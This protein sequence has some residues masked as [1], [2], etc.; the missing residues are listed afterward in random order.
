MHTASRILAVVAAAGLL[1]STVS[2]AMLLGPQP[3][4]SAAPTP[5]QNWGSQGE[6]SST[7]AVTVRW[8]NARNSAANTVDR[9]SSTVLPHTGGKTYG[10][11]T[12]DVR[13]RYEAS[14]GAQNG[15][16]GLEVSVSQTRELVNQSVTI[17]VAG[18]P[19]DGLPYLQVF[20][21]WGAPGTDG[22]PDPAATAPDPATCQVGAQ[23]ADGPA[24]NSAKTENTRAIY[25]DPLITTGDWKTDAD[26]TQ[27]AP[28]LAVDGTSV[29][30]E[31]AHNNVEGNVFF[32]RTTTNELSRLSTQLNGSVSRLMEIQTGSEA[33]GL[34]C[35][36]RSDAA[37]VRSCWLVVVPRFGDSDPVSDALNLSG[38][39]APTLW[40]QRLQ[41]KLDF[42]DVAETC[43]NGRAQ[44][45][46]AGSELVNR[47][48]ASW[49][50]SVCAASQVSLGFS[51][52]GD[53]QARQQLGAGALQAIFSSRPVDDP[54]KAIAAPV[55]VSG[56]A[57]AATIDYRPKC[58]GASGPDGREISADTISEQQ[59]TGQCGYP[60]LATAQQEL[61]KY[62]TLMTDIRLNARLVAKL[63]TQSYLSGIDNTSGTQ[64]DKAPWARSQPAHLGSDPEFLALNPQLKYAAQFSFDTLSGDLMVENL[65]SDAAQA[66][67]A[68]IVSDDGARSFLDGCP[69]LYGTTINPFFSTRTYKECV[70]DGP[71]LEAEAKAKRDATEL[72]EFFIDSP[73]M[74]PPDSAS[75]PQLSWYQ[76]DPVDVFGPQTLND[77]HPRSDYMST[78]GRNTFRGVYPANT[79]WCDPTTSTGC[80]VAGWKPAN[81]PKQIGGRSILSVTDT[82]TAARYQLPTAALCSD[83]GSAC[84]SA[85]AETLTRAADR[86]EQNPTGVG[87]LS[88]EDYSAGLYPVAMPVYAQ[89]ARTGLTAAGASVFADSLSYLTG[90]GQRTDGTSGS[91]PVGYAPLTPAMAADAATA[92]A[93]LRSMQ[94]APQTPRATASAAPAAAPPAT[95]QGPK[96]AAPQPAPVVPAAATPGP[97]TPVAAPPATATTGRT[98]IGFPQYGLVAGLAAA[99][100]AGLIA[101][102]LGR[103]RK[104]A[105]E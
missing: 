77:L 92:I 1:C 67:W 41:V 68:W 53:S 32:S 90:D 72:P 66:L 7:S 3:S 76:R 65:K 103:R 30:A 15:R 49:I 19:S 40:A 51:Q 79:E 31:V 98:E 8:D 38:P 62:G 36:Y 26:P 25:A 80:V 83:D 78:T 16:G 45:L 11:I 24:D 27:S 99:L 88:T 74:Y 58:G 96:A 59:A 22:Q 91:L 105:S 97:S 55:A 56:V 23:G 9:D 94:P 28:F 35:G 75:Y 100:L 29:R 64:I 71:R 20:Q 87:A 42:A 33:P 14:F 21:C 82:A 61:R 57:I 101:P 12:P 73:A 17:S 2:A 93:E 104:A 102:V 81:S 10:D 52:L 44:V 46:T 85:N 50:P 43:P 39:I 89:V 34:G 13:N 48:M 47:A 6:Y 86:F 37:S 18:A 4:A 60:D 84:V 95:A 54:T 69:D 70:V 63:L 5:V